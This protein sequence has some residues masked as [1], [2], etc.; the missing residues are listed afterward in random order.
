VH[1]FLAPFTMYLRFSAH[2]KRWNSGGEPIT[3]D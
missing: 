1:Y 3:Y 2:S